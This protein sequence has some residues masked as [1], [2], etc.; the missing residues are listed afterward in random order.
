VLDGPAG[1]TCSIH[2]KYSFLAQPGHHLSPQLLSSGAN[3][4]EA[5]GSGYTLLAFGVDDAPGAGLQHAAQSLGVPLQV[6]RDSYADGRQEYGSR[7]I[8]IRP[9][10]YVAWVG[11][12]PPA[13]PTRL[14]KQAAG[15]HQSPA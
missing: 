9:D 12:A 13:D 6:V 11:D 15:H 3:V 10:Q 5:L 8:L 4:F 1:G 7:L 14:L 2:G